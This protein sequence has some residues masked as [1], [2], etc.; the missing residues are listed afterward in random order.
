[1]EKNK[2]WKIKEENKLFS[3]KL[4]DVIEYD[5]YLP[6]KDI[7]NNFIALHM[8]DWVNVFALTKEGEVIMVKQHRMGK[9]LVTLEVPA[10][11]IEIGEN[12]AVSALRELEEE[13]GYTTDNLILLKKINVNPA[14]QNNN[15]YFYLALDCY[16]SKE[17]DL[18]PTEEV[19]MILMDQKEIFACRKNELI[20]NSVSL[21]AILLAKDYLVEKGL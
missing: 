17:Q 1:M 2:Q 16:Q 3:C 13:T 10:G 4:F 5:S 12:P 14:I 15:A 6:S 20:L 19:E 21:L 9:N 11:I 7:H 8:T 18:D